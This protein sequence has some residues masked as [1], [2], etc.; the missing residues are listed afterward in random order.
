MQFQGE[1]RLL[2]PSAD[3]KFSGHGSLPVLPANPRNEFPKPMPGFYL[4]AMGLCRDSPRRFPRSIIV[5]VFHREKVELTT[6]HTKYTKTIIDFIQRIRR[7][8]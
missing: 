7:S 3:L 8:G 1:I 6:K 5:A 2:V 4:Y